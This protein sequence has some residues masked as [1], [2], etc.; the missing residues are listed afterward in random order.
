MDETLDETEELDR[1]HE[2]LV[3]ILIENTDLRLDEVYSMV[4]TKGGR[5]T[6]H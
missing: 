4:F 5:I 3:Y 1:L 6:W 2:V